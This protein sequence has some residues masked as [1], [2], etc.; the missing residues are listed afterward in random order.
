VLLKLGK[1]HFAEKQG[2]RF[3]KLA[4]EAR[5]HI[6]EISAAETAAAIKRGALLIDVREREEFLRGH[7]PNAVHLARGTLELEIEKRAPDPATEIV[8]YCGAG[9]RSALSADALQRMG[10]SNVKSLGGGLQ[11]WIEARLPTWRSRHP[12]ED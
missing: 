5:S 7:I 3:L 11:A 2:E 6:A 4:A 12:I 10:H 8:V 1:L 9:N